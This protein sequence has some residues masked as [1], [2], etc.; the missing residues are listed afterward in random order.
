MATMGTP[1]YALPQSI[2]E[3]RTFITRVYGWM[4]GGLVT[5]GLVAAYTAAN[6]ALL[7]AIFGSGLFWVLI[8]AELGIV[9]A[10]WA[11]A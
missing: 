6:P 2:I 10:L 4:A 11:C 5:T 1:P 3:E 8:V 7:R 9:M